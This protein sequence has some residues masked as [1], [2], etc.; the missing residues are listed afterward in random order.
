[1]S[2]TR[3]RNVPHPTSP[4]PFRW[5]GVALLAAL[6]CPGRAPAQEAI[7]TDA[8]APPPAP[9]PPAP[10]DLVFSEEEATKLLLFESPA[11]SA[12]LHG[13]VNLEYYAFRNDP[14]YPGNSF[15]I[16]NVFLS[17]KATVA[18]TVSL[19]VELEY[20]H[21]SDVRLE[22]AFIDFEIARWL[23]IRAGRFSPPLSYERVHYA[24]PARL[25]TSRPFLADLAFHEWTDTGLA[26]FGR[27][28]GF[29]YNLGVFNGPRGLTE[30][31]IPSLDVID[32]NPNKAVVARL[33]FS[34]GPFLETGVAGSAGA[35]DPEGRR[36]FYLA[37]VDARFRSGRWDIWAEAD[38]RAGDDEPCDAAADVGCSPS[39]AGDHANKFGYY[40]LVGYSV[41]KEAHYVH[42]LKPIVRFDEIDDLTAHT[43]KRR[44]TAGLNWS[45]LS[46][47]VVKSELQWTFPVGTSL[48]QSQGLML[49]VAADF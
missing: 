44:L 29:S 21:G 49:S 40:I 25:T 43:G 22:R 34:P 1:M 19:F 37:E 31:G 23:T 30:A 8:P 48:P 39:Y 20:E 13:F 11:L 14:A 17:T 12:E 26:A 3:D 24:A 4:A 6:L 36:W 16:H 35:Y 18:S 41:V 15:D 32:N 27:V 10:G 7:P 42:Y 38:Y 5:A 2:S 33:N 9:R 46:H 28:G 45:P 47:V